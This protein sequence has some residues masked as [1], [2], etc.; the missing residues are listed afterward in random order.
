MLDDPE[1]NLSISKRC[2]LLDLPRSTYY[3]KPNKNM[4]E[5]LKYM[6][7]IDRIY[8]NYP[9][10]GS[11]KI[12][13]VLKRAGH[14]INRKKVQRLMRLM[15][16]KTMY[17]KPRTTLSNKEHYKYPYLLNGIK[18]VSPNDV[19]TTDIT[20]IP[21]RDSF[22]YLVAVMDLHT[23]YVLSWKI[24]DTLESDFCIEAIEQAIKC[25]GK[26]KI[27]NSDQGVQY[28]SKNYTQL[29]QKHNIAIS[30]SGKGSYRENI[31]IERL[32]RSLKYE[33]VYLTE[34]ESKKEAVRA[35]DQ[36]FRYYNEGRPHENL[37]Y[38]TPRE[39]YFREEMVA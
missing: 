22:V 31:H 36:Y 17:Q 3:Y 12:A 15:G 38:R 5:D 11:R 26:P 20:Y 8:L 13:K 33:E 37:S 23:R 39:L 34:Y 14:I 10:L 30:M 35:I 9:F 1:A 27:I 16:L 6:K 32:W 24:S 25:G 4:E 28:T 21:L 2:E 19:W 18:P 7:L 29:L